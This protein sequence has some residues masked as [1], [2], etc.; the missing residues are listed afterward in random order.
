MGAHLHL[1]K[2]CVPSALCQALLPPSPPASSSG[3]QAAGSTQ[4]RFSSCCVR[5]RGEK[6][7]GS[8]V[9][10][11][12]GRGRGASRDAGNKLSDVDAEPHVCP[13]GKP[14]TRLFGRLRRWALA[15]PGS[16]RRAGR[17]SPPL[18]RGRCRRLRRRR[19]R[20]VA[21]LL[22][23]CAALGTPH[24]LGSNKREPLGFS[25]FRV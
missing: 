10:A 1:L 4:A 12:A 15:A 2:R 13:W 11:D 14:L 17:L 22:A 18:L 8:S 24:N 3:C 25:E 7:L 21:R 23:A 16:V 19:G 6:A 20:L 5:L 9:T